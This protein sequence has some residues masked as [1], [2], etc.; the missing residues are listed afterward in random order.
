MFGEYTLY[1]VESIMVDSHYRRLLVA[2]EII[3]VG[4]GKGV[5]KVTSIP[6][7]KWFSS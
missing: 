1:Q 7:I 6:Q 4:S 5:V 3:L 2:D